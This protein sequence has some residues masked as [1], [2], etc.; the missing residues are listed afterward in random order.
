MAHPNPFREQLLVPIRSP[1]AIENAT[2]EVFNLQGQGMH[3]QTVNI[4][5]N[6][7]GLAEIDANSW[8]QG[9][10]LLRLRWKGQEMVVQKVVKM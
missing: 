2:L 3:S 8:P 9:M 4:P 10:Y 6:F 7:P 5:A 1:Q